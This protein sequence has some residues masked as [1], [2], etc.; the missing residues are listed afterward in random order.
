MVTLQP[1]ATRL[2]G[3]STVGSVR[4]RTASTAAFHASCARFKALFRALL[5]T[6]LRRGCDVTTAVKERGMGCKVFLLC[7]NVMK[8]CRMTLQASAAHCVCVWMLACACTRAESVCARA[9]CGVLWWRS[10][11]Q[12]M[13]HC[14]ATHTRTYSPAGGSGHLQH[15]A[16][17]AVWVVVLMLPESTGV[18]KTV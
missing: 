5:S 17:V 4:L 8:C 12:L 11:G 15:C 6:R 1:A 3:V 14:C 7:H 2:Q 10:Q 13:M 18:L 16:A 9:V